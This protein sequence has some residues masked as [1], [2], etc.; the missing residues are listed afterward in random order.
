MARNETLSIHL[1]NKSLLPLQKNAFIPKWYHFKDTALVD[2]PYWNYEAFELDT[3]SE[4][5]Y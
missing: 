5:K 3:M 1:L 4:D 2:I